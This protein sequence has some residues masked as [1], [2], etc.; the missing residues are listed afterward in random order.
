MALIHRDA[1]AAH[2][3]L[4]TWYWQRLSAVVLVLLLPPA[5]ILLLFL[6]RGDMSQ[7]ALL[8]VLDQPFT[9]ALHSILMLALLIHAYIGVKVI[10]EDYVPLRLR[11]P[12]LGALLP[13]LAGLGLWWLSM[14]WAWGS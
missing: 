11:L 3:G 10:V 2:N 5:Y 4:E 6:L 12:L 9:R 14:I 1:G 13:A 8:D 7:M